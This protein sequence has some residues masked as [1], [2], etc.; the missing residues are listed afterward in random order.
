MKLQPS[1]GEE[2]SCVT[3]FDRIPYKLTLLV[4]EGS[5]HLAD[6][7]ET[8]KKIKKKDQLENTPQFQVE[9]NNS[10]ED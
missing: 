3:G 9:A 8:R 4:G 2:D 7:L 6:N 1:A 5:Q 10:T